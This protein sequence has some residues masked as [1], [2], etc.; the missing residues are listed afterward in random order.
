MFTIEESADKTPTDPGYIRDI[1]MF[2][3]E[4]RDTAEVEVAFKQLLVRFCGFA[5]ATIESMLPD[6][7]VSVRISRDSASGEA[8]WTYTC[9]LYTSPSP[10][11]RG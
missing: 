3:N 11:D 1:S 7:Y 5:E 2:G 9:L 10:R 8:Q 4:G 6:N